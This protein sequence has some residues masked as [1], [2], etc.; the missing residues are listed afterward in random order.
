MAIN[1]CDAEMG[2]W[3]VGEGEEVGVERTGWICNGLLEEHCMNYQDVVYIILRM[4]W[5]D[6]LAS[7]SKGKAG[8]SISSSM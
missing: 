5:R 3:R 6:L 2:V 7:S 4:F 1:D 8:I